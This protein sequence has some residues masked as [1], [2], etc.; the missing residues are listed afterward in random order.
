MS[1][2][3]LID[4]NLRGVLSKAIER[5]NL[6]S[7]YPLDVVRVGDVPELPLGTN[8]PEILSWAAKENRILITDDRK[9]M[10]RHLEEFLKTNNYSPGILFLRPHM[11]ISDVL[12]YLVLISNAG[13]PKEF[14][15]S[16]AY[17]PP[18]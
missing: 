17:I 4:E 9:T 18:K 13:D 15:N 1:I 11:T 12:E 5:H 10:R 8:D 7:G 6:S 14:V 16:F 3:F 2:R